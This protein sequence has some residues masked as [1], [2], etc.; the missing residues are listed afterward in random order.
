MTAYVQQT[1]EESHALPMAVIP[2]CNNRA[3]VF[4]ARKLGA[5]RNSRGPCT[6]TLT[7]EGALEM[8]QH[9]EGR[10]NSEKTRVPMEA[11]FCTAGLEEIEHRAI[12]WG[13]RQA[14]NLCENAGRDHHREGRRPPKAPSASAGTRVAKRAAARSFHLRRA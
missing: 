6:L 4:A 14:P 8:L 12:L 1:R 5:V 10:R 13:N 2:L 7:A 11:I 9:K 3:H